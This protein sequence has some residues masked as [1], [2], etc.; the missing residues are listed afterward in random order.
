M[1]PFYVLKESVSQSGTHN[2]RNALRTVKPKVPR[3][4]DAEM[5]AHITEWE[6]RFR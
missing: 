3:I 5:Q 2:I 1:T 6:K 4:M